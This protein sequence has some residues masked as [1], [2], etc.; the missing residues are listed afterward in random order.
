[1]SNVASDDAAGEDIT[2]A[3]WL[4]RADSINYV[5][6]ADRG[7]VIL[8]GSHGGLY[9]AF[10]GLSVQP[11]GLVLND[12]G[13]GLRGAGIAALEEGDRAAVAV[14]TISHRSARIGDAGDMARRGIV[15]HANAVARTAGV[16]PGLACIEALRRLSRLAPGQA[17]AHVVREHRTEVP[18]AAGERV[19]C[20]DSASLI[21]A[22]DR[23]RVVVT[24]SH[25]GLIG[26][27]PGK[28]ISVAARFLAFNDAGCGCEN[29]GLGR[30]HPLDLRG[31]AAV[32]VSH[33]SAEIGN[34]LSTLHHGVVSHANAA[35]RRLGALAGMPL[36]QFLER[37]LGASVQSSGHI[38]C[39]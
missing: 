12:A 2:A 36:R 16:A 13:G 5:T 33:E 3:P 32:T 26:G 20:I 10:K 4:C 22:R 35:A 1:M 30:L 15:S 29:A 27:D 28:A 38:G 8:S 17:S 25:G 39:A 6:G 21:E 24:G 9:S 14:V 19:I 11:R 7:R 23:G 18:S 37:W 34:A 31:I